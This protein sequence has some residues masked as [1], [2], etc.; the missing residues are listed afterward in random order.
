M[1][2]PYM[3]PFRRTLKWA[4]GFNHDVDLRYAEL[5]YNPPLGPEE[6][7]Q[8]ELSS[9]R[10]LG[11][12]RL[13]FAITDHD[14][15][16]GGLELLKRQ[17]DRRATIA[18]GEELSVNHDGHLFHLGVVGLPA[19]SCITVHDR[20]QCASREGRLGELFEC[21]KST[22]CLVILNHPLLGWDGNCAHAPLIVNFLR[23]FGWGIDA[24]EYNGMRCRAENDAVLK[25]ATS[26][27]KPV[28]GGGDSHL[29]AASSAICA[30]ANA[31]TFQ[32]YV[33][34]V[35]SGRAVTLLT[36]EYFAP[37]RWKMLLRVLTFIAHYRKIARYRGHP[38]DAAIGR[39]WV[40]L[41]PVGGASR[42]FLKL[43]AAMRLIR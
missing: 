13:V 31:E 1:T 15:V 41:D 40:L 24:L 4:F 35:K 42:A 2:L 37:L 3:R 25:L 43:A 21:L 23:R 39:G 29:L 26:V 18:L 20:I 6:L 11:F 34:E 38:V 22:G 16:D 32:D 30:S 27:G 19:E 33:E 7:Y 36:R 12:D 5:R 8:L 28:V 10:R 14:S 9:F 17:G